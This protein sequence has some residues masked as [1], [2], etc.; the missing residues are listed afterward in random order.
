MLANFG[1]LAAEPLRSRWQAGWLA[2]N[3]GDPGDPG[4]A[5]SRVNVADQD[6][7]ALT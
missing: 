4:S 3:P 6:V 2:G 7:A 5:I 1:Y